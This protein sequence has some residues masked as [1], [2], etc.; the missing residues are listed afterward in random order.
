MV[1]QKIRTNYPAVE[2]MKHHCLKMC[3]EVWNVSSSLKAYGADVKDGALLG[4]PGDILVDALL[5]MV[6]G[7]GKLASALNDLAKDIEQALNHMK[8]ADGKAGTQF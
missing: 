4:M 1:D 5:Q 2:D 3:T 6:K 8:Q 7:T